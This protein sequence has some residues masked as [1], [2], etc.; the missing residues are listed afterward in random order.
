MPCNTKL[1]PRQTLSGRKLEVKR[2][3]DT[4]QQG[5]A[6][7]RFGV[8]LSPN[9]AIAFTGIPD[10]IRDGVTD[11]CVYRAIANSGSALAR[12]AVQRAEIL[13]GRSVDKQQVAVGAHAHID[14]SGGLTWHDHK[15]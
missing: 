4:I 13:A 2:A 12:A 1:K 15:G 8:K 14:S 6:T 10:S 5:L 7:N 11:A 9:G 3:I